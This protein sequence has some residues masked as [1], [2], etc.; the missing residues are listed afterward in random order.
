MSFQS[1]TVY[2]FVHFLGNQTECYEILSLLQD[3]RHGKA[4]GLVY[5]NGEF[6]GCL[7][8]CFLFDVGG[9]LVSNNCCSVLV[10][11]IA[12]VSHLMLS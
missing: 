10:K 12:R 1:S 9:A 2:L 6:R 7:L 3:N 11:V 8:C 5:K 4:W